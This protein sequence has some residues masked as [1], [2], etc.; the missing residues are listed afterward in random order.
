MPKAFKPA[1]CTQCRLDLEVHIMVHI[2]INRLCMIGCIGLGRGYC[3]YPPRHVCAA[4]RRFLPY[5]L[6][7]LHI[8][9]HY[10]TGASGPTTYSPHH[11]SF[12]G[13]WALMRCMPAPGPGT[14]PGGYGHRPP[15][16]LASAARVAFPNV[17]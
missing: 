4:D 10:L 3:R 5:L 7:Y 6:T 1:A 2:F 17:S 8:H 12:R 16:M 15:G 9:K 13:L 14:S 11:C